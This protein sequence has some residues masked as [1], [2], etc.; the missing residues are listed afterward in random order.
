MD[1]ENYHHTQQL[2]FFP[3]SLNV[4]TD[5]EGP[6]TSLPDIK[7]LRRRRQPHCPRPALP[8]KSAELHHLMSRMKQV[9]RWDKQWKI[10][11]CGTGSLFL[12]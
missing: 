4:V 6:P 8:D 10:P 5:P 3:S 12:Y 2:T 1:F 9:C 11:P 7:F